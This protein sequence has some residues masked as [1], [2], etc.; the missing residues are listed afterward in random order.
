MNPARLV[1]GTPD[2]ELAIAHTEAASAIIHAEFPSL[3]LKLARLDRHGRPPHEA[4]LA[5]DIDL[6]VHRTKDLP[7]E[8]PDG[9]VIGAYLRRQTPFDVLVSVGAETLDELPRDSRVIARSIRR[10]GQLG[11]YRSDI[12]LIE[13]PGTLQ[14]WRRALDSGACRA[15]VIG[16]DTVEHLGLQELVG[17]I[18]SP[19]VCLPAPGQGALAL[20]ARRDAKDVLKLVRSLNDPGTE[21]EVRAELAVLRGLGVPNAAAV[22]A[23]AQLDGSCL[24]LDGL[25][26]GSEDGDMARYQLEG[27]LDKPEALGTELAERLLGLGADEFLR[28]SRRKAGP[29]RGRPAAEADI[30]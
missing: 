24:M 4:L 17:E 6:V 11:Q 1:I 27:N 26:V 29:K 28:A 30:I 23:L 19:G 21:A 9:V 2:D 5:G 22:A 10:R 15:M 8:I 7:A 18:L 14:D 3:D 12:A 25:V 16:A 13:A 20:A